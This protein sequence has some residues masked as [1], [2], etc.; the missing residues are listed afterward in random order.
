MK[1]P[2]HHPLDK[3][4][5]DDK[6]FLLETM[7]PFVDERMKVPLAMYIKIMELQLILRGFR[8]YSYVNQ[9]GLCRDINNQDDVL[10]TLAGCG[11]GDIAGQMNQ[12]KSMMNMMNIMNTM[13]EN[14]V[15]PGHSGSF[16]HEGYSSN[17]N[18]RFQ[19][20]FD[21]FDGNEEYDTHDMYDKYSGAYAYDAHKAYN[22]ETGR[23]NYQEAGK[24]NYY[25]TDRN[26]YHEASED[27]HQDTYLNNPTHSYQNI[28]EKNSAEN[29][30]MLDNIM[31]L[32][33][34]YDYSHD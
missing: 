13:G 10:E 22:Q 7:I 34:E 6:L 4:I 29:D 19:D 30:S 24:N 21:E 28:Y 18:K 14:G 32:L 27:N 16:G 17:M 23:S 25:E 1:G 2:F 3:L 31:H 11:F 9:C 15:N 12:F 33:D 26:N 5:N 20:I 8:S